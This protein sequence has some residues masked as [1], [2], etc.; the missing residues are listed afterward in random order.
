MTHRL[1]VR[2]RGKGIGPG[3]YHCACC[4]PAPKHRRRWR[5]RLRARLKV[6]DR[7]FNRGD[8]HVS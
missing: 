5:H 2:L 3:G 1:F 4:G 6:F 7:R 8:S